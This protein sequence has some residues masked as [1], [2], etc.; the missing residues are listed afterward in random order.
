MPQQD[1]DLFTRLRR[2]GVRKP[3]AKTLSR[4]TEDASKKAIDAGLLAVAELRALADEIEKR[5][6]APE[7]ATIAPSQSAPVT[8]ASAP[9]K[10][11]AARASAPAKPRATRASA[12]KKSGSPSRP[13]TSRSRATASR[14]GSTPSRSRASASRSSAASTSVAP[15]GENKEKILAALKSGPQT[16]SEVGQST[17]IATATVSAALTRL[18]K[19]GEVTKATRGYALPG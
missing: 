7:A 6:P 2:A 16:A 19:S 17:G 4:L 11:R 15:R 10:P 3:V 14:S 12:P 13:T 9:A 18:S 1:D 8:S 5:L